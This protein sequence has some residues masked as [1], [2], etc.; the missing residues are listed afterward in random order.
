MSSGTGRHPASRQGW[1]GSQYIRC[2]E[3]NVSISLF[4]GEGGGTK[5]KGQNVS[6]EERKELLN[7]TEKKEMAKWEL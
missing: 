5:A 2:I 7:V 6:P 1:P 4:Y 3:Y